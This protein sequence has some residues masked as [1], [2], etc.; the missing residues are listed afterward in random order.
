MEPIVMQG[1]TEHNEQLEVCLKL[2]DGTVTY[3]VEP[4]EWPGRGRLVVEAQ[5]EGGM[6]T[7]EVDLLQLIAWLKANRPDLLE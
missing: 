5:C 2:S 7:T 3:G 1:V 4:D 6:A